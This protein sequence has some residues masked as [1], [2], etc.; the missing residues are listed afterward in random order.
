MSPGQ[1]RG[2]RWS[3]IADPDKHLEQIEDLMKE[4][5][6]R[7]VPTVPQA[8]PFHATAAWNGNDAYAE[9][10]QDKKTT[11]RG[12][13][14]EVAEIP[15]K[16]SLPIVAGWTHVAPIEALRKFDRFGSKAFYDAA[17]TYAAFVFC[18]LAAEAWLRQ[19]ASD[20]VAFLIHENTQQRG[21]DLRDWQKRFRD[22]AI[23]EGLAPDSLFPLARIKDELLFT[24]KSGSR[25][26]Q[27][28]DACAW[29]IGRQ[30]ARQQD[31]AEMFESISAQ[32]VPPSVNA[33]E[34]F[35]CGA[36]PT[37]L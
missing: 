21:D 19:H 24:S 1:R 16:L 25:M 14:K 22:K 18:V 7:H 33:S 29:L 35:W 8:E 36:R 10:K 30:L 6:L 32:I 17:P 3:I 26:I 5:R 2:C 23:T 11:L 13:L 4:A 31:T 37:S 34:L 27:L 15:A 20:E 12:Y 28:A 9:Y